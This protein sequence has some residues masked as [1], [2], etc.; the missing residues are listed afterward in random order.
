MVVGGAGSSDCDGSRFSVSLVVSIVAF[1]VSAAGAV[2]RADIMAVTDITQRHIL[3]FSRAV[4]Q[5]KDFHGGVKASPSSYSPVI[6]PVGADGA[7]VFLVRVI[8]L[9]KN[10][11]SD[12]SSQKKKKKKNHTEHTSLN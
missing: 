2:D 12:K 7:G 6:G 11:G 4:G 5:A 3:G 10:T 9:K 8:S 1:A